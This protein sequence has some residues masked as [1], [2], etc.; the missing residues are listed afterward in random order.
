MIA[1]TVSTGLWQNLRVTVNA[2]HHPE[3][4]VIKTFDRKDARLVLVLLA[5][6][7]EYVEQQ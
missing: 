2:N 3:S 7:C 6:L 1:E 4:P 5:A